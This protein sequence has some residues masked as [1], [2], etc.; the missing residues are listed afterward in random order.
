MTI[1]SKQENYRYD[2]SRVISFTLLS[3][4]VWGLLAQAILAGLVILISI[5]AGHTQFLSNL[6]FSMRL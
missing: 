6:C 2:I 1:F 3:D 4:C 5:Q